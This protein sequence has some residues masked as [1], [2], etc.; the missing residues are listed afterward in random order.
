M[1]LK[2]GG[3]EAMAEWL[4]LN[5]RNLAAPQQIPVAWRQ[6]LCCVSPAGC[7]G[8]EPIGDNAPL[9]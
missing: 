3:D 1:M 4:K 5:L 8:V 2:R 7:E 9:G 6:W